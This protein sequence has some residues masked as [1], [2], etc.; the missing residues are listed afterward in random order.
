MPQGLV[1]NVTGKGGLDARCGL[2]EWSGVQTWRGW[3]LPHYVLYLY[4]ILYYMYICIYVY[5]VVPRE[6]MDEA[7]QTYFARFRRTFR[8]VYWPSSSAVK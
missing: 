7:S 3:E 6:Q 5:I 4:T 8:P 2:L 1:V